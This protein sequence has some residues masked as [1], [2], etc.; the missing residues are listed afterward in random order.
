MELSYGEPS[1]S[2]PTSPAMPPD[3]EKV[4]QVLYLLERFGISDQFYHELSMINPSLPRYC[5]S[6]C[7]L[8][9]KGI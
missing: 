7:S 9:C 8:R 6:S 4:Q 5:S 3:G 2:A 1:T